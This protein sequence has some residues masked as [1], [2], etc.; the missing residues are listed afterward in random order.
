M[1]LQIAICLVIYFIFYLIQNSNYI[2]SADI[3]N[4]TKE[5][6]SYDINIE[7]IFN[8]IINGINSF[9]NE[10]VLDGTNNTI[11]NEQ[12]NT[13]NINTQNA[14]GGAKLASITI[15]D[16]TPI[17][18]SNKEEQ[19]QENSNEQNNDGEDKKIE[20]LT[21]EEY[22]KTFNLIKPI[23]GIVS[24]EFGLR[25]VDNPIVSK[26]HKGIDIAAN[27]GTQIKAAMDGTVTISSTTGSYGYHIQLTNNDVSTM[28]A[29]CS[30]LLVN[31]GDNVTKGQVI[32]EVGSTGNSTNPHLHFEIKRGN[33]YINPRDILEF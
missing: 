25:N 15:E 19:N 16:I 30:K 6:L 4:K 14:I 5:I 21:D 22:I 11:N 20:E 9:S 7:E 2:F 8:N 17:Q 29:H 3:I 13:V 31:V 33:N 26:D 10:L 24:S 28:Y 1:I 27:T 23:E 18:N 32:A 12:N